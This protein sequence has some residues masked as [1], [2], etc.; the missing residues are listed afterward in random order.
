MAPRVGL[1]P[2]T[3]GLIGSQPSTDLAGQCPVAKPRLSALGSNVAPHAST[4]STCVN[5]TVEDG[6]WHANFGHGNWHVSRAQFQPKFQGKKLAERG[7]NSPMQ[8][9]DSQRNFDNSEYSY[10]Q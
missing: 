1:E 3:N 4:E 7:I 10:H 5:G 6:A 9:I 2:T 8:D